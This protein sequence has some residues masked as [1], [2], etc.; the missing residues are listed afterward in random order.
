[1]RPCR[2]CPRPPNARPR[3]RSCSGRR[4]KTCRAPPIFSPEASSWP[5]IAEGR[6]RK[7]FSPHPATARESR[8]GFAWSGWTGKVYHARA[9]AK[10]TRIQ[11]NVP[12]AEA[13]TVRVYIIDP[14]NFEGGRKEKVVVAGQTFGPFDNF[15]TGRWI[16]CPLSA[17]QTA[18]GKVEI[19]A[20]NARSGAN[21]VL[22]LI[23]W[24]GK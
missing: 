15:Q 18:S 9:D 2:R 3:P 24:V 16:E 17:E 5:C 23:E 19:S 8:Q 7:L 10:E 22:S 6:A 11:L 1:M 14:D 21:A 4:R 12:K 13:G 20:M